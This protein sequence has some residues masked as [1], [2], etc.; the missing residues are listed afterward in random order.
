MIHTLYCQFHI[1]AR[2]LQIMIMRKGFGLIAGL[3]FLVIVAVTPSQA[4]YIFEDD[5]DAGNSGVGVLNYTGFAKWT[6]SGGTVDLIGNGYF[7][8]YPGNGLYVDLDGSTG[9]AGTMSTN[10]IFSAGTYEIEFDLGN[11]PYGNPNEVV[12]SLGFGSWSTNVTRTPGDGLDEYSFIVTTN[13]AGPLTFR[14]LG[15]DN[16][17]AILDCVE[18]T[19]VPIPGAVWLLG[20]GLLGLLG[21]KRRILG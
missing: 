2:R 7:D 11:S 10:M 21:L 3:V 5:F 12:I 8:F 15:G 19:A 6:V 20:S 18:V 13:Q 14:N 17:G 9:Q 4:A 16:I 1:P